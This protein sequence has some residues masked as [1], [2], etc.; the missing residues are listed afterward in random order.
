M[1]DLSAGSRTSVT[2]VGYIRKVVQVEIPQSW[3]HWSFQFSAMGLYRKKLKTQTDSHRRAE[4]DLGKHINST[5]L[6]CLHF[7]GFFG[8]QGG[9]NG[10]SHLPQ[11]NVF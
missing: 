8:S 11:S 7:C 2:E 10:V 1:S 5:Q 6:A 4:L 3:L 9:C